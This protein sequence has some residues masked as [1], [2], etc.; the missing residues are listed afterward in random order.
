LNSPDWSRVPNCSLARRRTD[1]LA[2]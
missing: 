2:S 1:E